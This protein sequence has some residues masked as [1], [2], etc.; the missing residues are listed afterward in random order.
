VTSVSISGREAIAEVMELIAR[1]YRDG[2]VI[3]WSAEHSATLVPIMRLSL[4]YAPGVEPLDLPGVEPI[5][6]EADT[7]RG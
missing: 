5:D 3:A 1:H 7:D 6:E 4:V 2:Y